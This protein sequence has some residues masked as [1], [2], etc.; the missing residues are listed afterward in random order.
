VRLIDNDVYPGHQYQYRIKVRLQNPNWAG[1]K[2]GKGEPERKANYELV[3][4]RADADIEIIEGPFVEMRDIIRVPREEHLFAIDPPLADPKDRWNAIQLKPGEALMQIQ[5]WL[6]YLKIG[7]FSEP[8]GDWIVADMIARR[9]TYLGGTQV[10]PMPIW[11]SEF[12]RYLMREIPNAK[13]RDPKRGVVIDP[14]S[15]G[16]KQIVVD[17]QGGTQRLRGTTRIIDDEAATEILLLDEEGQLQVRRSHRDRLDPDRAKR[18]ENWRSWVEQ[19]EKDT[20]TF[21][22]PKSEEPFKFQ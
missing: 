15:P 12:N 16:P 14:I 10:V 13:A 6:P 1:P 5:R 19:V 2:D 22:K 21:L 3:R 20:D 18:E 7:N 8:V 9:G 17:I 11:S 4:R